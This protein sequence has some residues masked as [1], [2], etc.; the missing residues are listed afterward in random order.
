[1]C[2]INAV[3]II[4]VTRSSTRVGTVVISKAAYLIVVANAV[5]IKTIGTVVIPETTR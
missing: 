1:M 4:I 3:L 5:L 2:F